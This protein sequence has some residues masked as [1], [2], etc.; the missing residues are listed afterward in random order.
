MLRCISFAF[1]FQKLFPLL[2][3]VLVAALKKEKHIWIT[4]ALDLK[5]RSI[6]NALKTETLHFLVFALT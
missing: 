2:K 5:G 4:G 6:A 3:F 1:I